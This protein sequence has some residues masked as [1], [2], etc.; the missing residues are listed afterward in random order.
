M[1]NFP[2]NSREPRVEVK[3]PTEE[4]RVQKVVEGSVVRRKKPIGRQF[5]EIFFGER[6]KNVLE[7][8]VMDVLIPAARDMVY[9]SF[10]QGVQRA[11]YGGNRPPMRSNTRQSAFGGGGNSQVPYNRYSTPTGPSRRDER[12]PMSRRARTNHDFDEIVIP[13]RAEAEDVIDQ[14][15]QM[16]ERYGQVSVKELYELVGENYHY[17]DEKWGWT[18]LRGA[19]VRRIADGYLLDLPRTEPLS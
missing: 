1:E 4:K 5:S 17:T 7:Y 12:A 3:E 6:A 11:I 18:D 13:S 10:T 15:F 8:V 2:S 19:G 9:D 16:L 14:M